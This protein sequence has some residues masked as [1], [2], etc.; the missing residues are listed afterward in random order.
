MSRPRRSAGSSGS[1]LVSRQDSSDGQTALAI[2]RAHDQ[3]SAAAISSLSP[4]TPLT[5]RLGVHSGFSLMYELPS[6][7]RSPTNVSAT[8]RPPTGPSLRVLIF[9]LPFVVLSVTSVSTVSAR[10]Y[11]QS[12]QLPANAGSI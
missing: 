9:L 10:T 11:V 1:S 4:K 3:D 8:M 6:P 7:T 5:A 2:G 12:G